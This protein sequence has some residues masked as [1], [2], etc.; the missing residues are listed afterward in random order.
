MIFHKLLLFKAICKYIYKSKIKYI[1]IYFREKKILPN[2][3]F[4]KKEKIRSSKE[5]TIMNLKK[6]K[7]R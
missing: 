6:K 4:K 3:N 1:I 2:I 7:G 5:I